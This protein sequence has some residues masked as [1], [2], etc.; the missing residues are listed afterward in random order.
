MAEMFGTMFSAMAG[1]PVNLLARPVAAPN[2]SF[3][4]GVTSAVGGLAGLFK[5]KYENTAAQFEAAQIEGEAAQE[6]LAGRQQ[7]ISML[8][9]LNSDLASINAAGFASGLRGGGSIATAKAEADK[10]AMDNIDIGRSNTK[11]KANQLRGQAAQVRISGKMAKAGA[12]VDV[13]MAGLENFSRQV[14]RG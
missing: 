9:R 11:L 1:N 4:S 2:A 12:L 7:V 13:G 8:G 3:M 14:R 10:I 5:A 6:E